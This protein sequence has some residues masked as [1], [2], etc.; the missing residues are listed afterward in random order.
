M[1]LRQLKY[2][3][4]VAEATLQAMQRDPS[5][6]VMG[7]G[8]DDTKGIFGTTR[9]AF[10][11]FGRERVFDVPLSENSLTGWGTGAA[12]MGLRPLMVHA[13]ND[14][15]LLAM[16][17]IANHAA[18]WKYLNGS[19]VP[20]TM[21][22]IIGRGW[23]QGA[24]HSQ[25]L[26][27]TFAHFPG[28]KVVMP[29]SPYDAKGLLLSSIFDPSPVIVLE[30]RRLYE[31]AGHVP[32]RFYTVPL[33]RAKVLREGGDVTIVALSDMVRESLRAIESLAGSGIEIELIDART[34]RPL[35]AATIIR[36]VRKTGRLVVCDTSWVQF[37]VSAEISSRVCES[38]FRHLR[39]PIVRVGLP[40]CP[41]PC[42]YALEKVFYPDYLDIVK[43][44]RKVLEPKKKK[45]LDSFRPRRIH[46]VDTFR[47]PF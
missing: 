26:Q 12:L 35:D 15:V 8:V 39:A 4:A 46:E 41:T 33:G 32:R 9:L 47:G 17:Q 28:L 44:V 29:A 18:K 13:R 25:S 24:Q 16:D 1:G 3:E 42:S 37:G 31:K 5:V 14:F 36:S 43:A 21:R 45:R 20:W 23:G 34:V 2:R 27:A 10:E 38:A 40:D 11:A 7:E 22:A 19:G 6:F 30:H